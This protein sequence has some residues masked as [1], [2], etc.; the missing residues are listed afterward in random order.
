MKKCPFCS[1]EIQD[2]AI[3]CKH[4]KEFLSEIPT[5]KKPIHNSI[6]KKYDLISNTKRINKIKIGK[7]DIK[8]T[9]L[10]W[11]FILLFIF[12]GQFIWKKISNLE[13]AQKIS[14]TEQE[15]RTPR[16]RPVHAGSMGDQQKLSYALGLDIG[17]YFKNLNENIDLDILRQGVVDSYYG[18]TPLL[19]NEEAAEIQQNFVQRL[20]EKRLKDNIDGRG[21]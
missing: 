12:V 9:Y 17:S 10:I 5:S 3:K 2:K 11:I 16:K 15:E 13:S 18:N 6:F 21:P 4:C 20:Q 19:S 7:F 14:T 8:P 1:E